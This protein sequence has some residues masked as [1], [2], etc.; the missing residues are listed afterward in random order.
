MVA[1]GQFTVDDIKK[2]ADDFD[3]AGTIASFDKMAVKEEAKQAA[4]DITPGYDKK[5][6]FF[7]NI[8]CE[9]SAGQDRGGGYNRFPFVYHPLP[10]FFLFGYPFISR[11]AGVFLCV[12]IVFPAILDVAVCRFIREMHASVLKFQ[13][14][15]S[16][17]QRCIVVC[18]HPPIHPPT[19][20]IEHLSRVPRRHLF[21]M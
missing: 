4:P 5:S 11:L 21:V 1:S 13:N 3:F 8:S 20:V 16:R 18:T 2:M 19:V 6:S 15:S 10:S 14:T 12:C 17:Y 7:D 9:S